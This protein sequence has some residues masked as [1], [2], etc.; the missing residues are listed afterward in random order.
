MSDE[1]TIAGRTFTTRRY[2]VHLIKSIS[3]G[4][5][6]MKLAAAFAIVVGAMLDLS[7]GSAY[8]EGDAA[9]GEGVFNRCKTCHTIEEGGP[10]KMGPNLHG[11]YGRQAGTAPPGSLHSGKLEESGVIWDDQT[12]TEWLAAPARFIKGVKMTFRLTKDQDIAD[13]IA[14]LKVNSPDAE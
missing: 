8:A 1:T 5:G 11:V 3:V 9:A 7:A 6:P 14:Y 12:L 10:P 13:I 2:I 4:S